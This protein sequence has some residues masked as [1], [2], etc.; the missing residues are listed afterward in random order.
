MR[1]FGISHRDD[2]G[3]GLSR[4]PREIKERMAEE[5]SFA[6]SPLRLI[7]FGEADHV[8]E[9]ALIRFAKRLLSMLIRF[10]ARFHRLRGRLDKAEHLLEKVFAL[11]PGH[12]GV[13]LNL[14]R[15]RTGR[16]RFAE[17]RRGLAAALT[18]TG[19][20]PDILIELIKLQIDAGEL[21]AARINLRSAAKLHAHPDVARFLS[22][23]VEELEGCY[24]RAIEI[25]RVGLRENPHDFGLLALSWRCASR[26]ASPDEAASL[27]EDYA[28]HPE[29][30]PDGLVEAAEFLAG[31]G[32]W[33]LSLAALDRAASMDPDETSATLDGARRL[34]GLNDPQVALQ[35]LKKAASNATD[36]RWA[37][38]ILALCEAELG[39]FAAAIKQ[40][41]RL[42]DYAHGDASLIEF[43]ADCRIRLAN[44][45]ED[46]ERHIEDALSEIRNGRIEFPDDPNLIAQ[47][48]RTLRMM[49]RLDE[50]LKLAERVPETARSGQAI[51][52]IFDVFMDR[53]R[54]ELAESLLSGLPEELRRTTW[55]MQFRAR[56]LKE[57]GRLEEAETML[58]K[59]S[60]LDPSLVHVAIDLARIRTSR[61]YIAEAKRG[62]ESAP[63]PAGSAPAVLIELA[64]MQIESWEF[65]QA[66]D[67][68]KKASEGGGSADV[69]G[70]LSA[71]IEELKGGHERA[72]ELALEGLVKNPDNF[73]LHA[74]SW[75][76]ASRSVSAD[77][78]AEMC[79][80]F[81]ERPDC[82][83]E[84]LLE[85]ARFMRGSK[86]WDRGLAILEAAAQ[87]SDGIE[88]AR[89]RAEC[90]IG[91]NE[92][93]KAT[94]ILEGS[95]G[96][97]PDDRNTALALARCDLGLGN[98]AKALER[99]KRLETDVGRDLTSIVM[100]AE[101]H[102][103]LADNDEETK[104]HVSKALSVVEDGYSQFP[105]HPDLVSLEIRALRKAGQEEDALSRADRLPETSLRGPA[106]GALFELY[107]ESDHPDRADA[108]L[109]GLPEELRRTIWARQFRARLLSVQGR[110]AD[111]ENLLKEIIVEDPG[112]VPAILE[113]ARLRARSGQIS[114][115][116]QQLADALPG[117]GYTPSLLFELTRMLIDDEEYDSAQKFLH[118]ASA[119]EGAPLAEIRLQS[120]RIEELRGNAVVALEQARE[121]LREHP[122]DI[123][124]ETMTWRCAF[125]AGF[126]DEAVASCQAYA[127]R[128]DCPDGGLIEAAKFLMELERW[129]ESLSLLDRSVAMNPTS[130]VV[131]KERA[132]CFIGLNDARN[133]SQALKNI[134]DNKPGNRWAAV[135]LARCE[136][137][138]GDV[139]SALDRL[140]SLEANSGTDAEIRGLK[141][142]CY[143][144]LANMSAQVETHVENALAI[145]GEG[146]SEDPDNPILIAVEL[147]ALRK[148]GRNEDALW[149]A[150][151]IQDSTCEGPAIGAIF[152]LYMETGLPEEADA[153]LSSLPD[154][155]RETPWAKLFRAR[156][157]NARRRDREAEELLEGILAK[158]PGHVPAILELARLRAAGGRV[159]EAKRRLVEMRR[160]TG[161]PRDALVE[162]ARLQIGDREHDDALN[163]LE[164][165]ADRGGRTVDA[166][167]LAAFVEERR[168]NFGRALEMARE[169]LRE[170]PGHVPFETM[171]WRCTS[172]N[173]SHDEAE[174]LCEAYA[175]RTDCPAEGLLEAARFMRIL[176]RWDKCLALLKRAEELDP[177][178][179]AATL[180]RAHFLLDRRDPLNASLALKELAKRS[181]G[182]RWAE[183]LLAQCEAN[184][185]DARSALE[186]LDRLDGKFPIHTAST[187]IRAECLLMI[188][189][190]G[191]AEKQ[192]GLLRDA[193]AETRAWA[194]ARRADLELSRGLVVEAL[195]GIEEAIAL[196]PD[197]MLL[198]QRRSV[199]RLLNGDF[200]GARESN[201]AYVETRY[202]SDISRML[203][204]KERSSVHGRILNE[205][206]LIGKDLPIAGYFREPDAT[207]ALP[208][209]RRL[210]DGH[211]ESTPAAMALL[212]LMCRAGHV[213]ESP[214]PA[215]TEAKRIPRR[216][217]QFWD[218]T[219]PPEQVVWLMEE[220]AR[221]AP[222]FEFRRFDRHEGLEYLRAKDETDAAKSF[223][224]APNA[225]AKADILR[226][227][228]LW[229]EGGIY[230]DADDRIVG[231]VDDLLP[232][233]MDFVGYQDEYMCVANNFLAASAG[234]PVI[235]DALD[236]AVRAYLGHR[237]DE[238]WL[239]SGPGAITRAIAHRGTT[240]EGALAPGIW[241]MPSYRLRPVVAAHVDLNYKATDAHW[242]KDLTDRK[243][244]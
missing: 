85:A 64:R 207:G 110:D 193:D 183:I 175:A 165:A 113:L 92:L 188:G 102:L 86:R 227:A 146:Y 74:L 155:I 168:G 231:K 206:R 51:G 65:D 217:F 42:G 203:S 177:G 27:C 124:F 118:R 238:L 12:V 96:E 178:S 212:S 54:V 152:E 179:S 184:L 38:M 115:A 9:R 229:H 18:P 209:L 211:E 220:N 13:A 172:M 105:D 77:E 45:G 181:H 17:A 83:V 200:E 34:I 197:N 189:D 142:E 233:G 22:A 208:E 162:L 225:T 139:R 70:F 36:S 186:R 210:I 120:A 57:L 190:V 137:E 128:K 16:G 176:A 224:Q 87:K 134:L 201:I 202:A 55:A 143:L 138:R 11:D 222:D 48:I 71:R 144:R 116:R 107:M 56:V 14:A 30:P 100:M 154:T 89:E 66:A 52:A 31:M 240:V 79:E 33:D 122:E 164:E 214:P 63:L 131:A 215:A 239:A 15:I 50:A 39:E 49:G 75:R 219:E 84:G 3:R 1:A 171:L 69:I 133:A 5:S 78:A 194:G 241:I 76:C 159:S 166:M 117:A 150:A 169:G 132:K 41:E 28:S 40:L 126:L 46:A 35:V 173:A 199:I 234:H 47:E 72:L 104:T 198:N 81:L 25:A 43:M 61:G 243:K 91:K 94:E 90:L 121:G 228:L 108:L 59:V 205:F 112:H 141:A 140:D 161:L 196:D 111:S 147:R 67:N 2:Y 95:I 156:L 236:T 185:G 10:R 230:L 24:E 244:S 114:L 187:Q 158:L 8:A 204:R 226:L 135:A 242:V 60:A 68:L 106:A 101:C 26:S 37:M 180:E 163:T 151:M 160:S 153:F 221:S 191:A 103:Q 88:V 130:S 93:K 182:N 148:A 23:R 53:G 6:N 4:R 129:G 192:L 149:R 29:C 20:D 7:P 195:A 125:A 145:V 174:E 136:A 170:H 127:A 218:E 237:S 119:R 32:R 58:E 157:L 213:T 19:F 82:P 80:T 99:M 97:S 73:A 62:L 235:R 44:L 232:T 21:E 223:R 123:R 216:I 98:P 109:S 167:R